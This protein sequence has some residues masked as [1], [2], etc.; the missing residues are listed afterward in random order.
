MKWVHQKCA[1]KSQILCATV[2]FGL[3]INFSSFTCLLL[4]F[5][6][7]ICVAVVLNV[8]CVEWNECSTKTTSHWIDEETQLFAKLSGIAFIPVCCFLVEFTC[9]PDTLVAD[10]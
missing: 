7:H 4:E 8:T 5:S 9:E 1:L 6:F 2:V 3:L 10:H